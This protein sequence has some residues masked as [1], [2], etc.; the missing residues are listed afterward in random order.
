[1]AITEGTPRPR[2]E[3]I[4]ERL[5]ESGAGGEFTVLCSPTGIGGYE[6]PLTVDITGPD[7]WVPGSVIAPE[8]WGMTP[9]T[10]HTA[11]MA[12]AACRCRQLFI[13]KFIDGD[14]WQRY[15]ADRQMREELLR[16]WP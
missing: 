3:I 13:S 9:E 1:M 5:Y 10:L 2:L 15:L 12:L 6:V 16:C 8:G 7:P 11:M 14:T 4:N